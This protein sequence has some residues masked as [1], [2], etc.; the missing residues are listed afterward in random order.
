MGDD[1]QTKCSS[2]CETLSR[3]FDLVF[4]VGFGFLAIFFIFSS[5]VDTNGLYGIVMITYFIFFAVFM[6][7]AFLQVKFL[8]MYCGFLKSGL[9]T[10]AM[11]YAFLSTLAFAQIDEWYCWV[12]G[13][14]D[15]CMTI[16]QFLRAC[17][18]F[19]VKSAK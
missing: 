17:G 19:A 6:T 3:F 15:S 1:T 8:M 2:M 9:L 7:M 12:V 11:F 13:G 4:A 10:K 18:A 14:I 16:V 5:H